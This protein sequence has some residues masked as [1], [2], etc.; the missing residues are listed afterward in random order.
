MHGAM[1]KIVCS[2]VL[3]AF[4]FSFQVSKIVNKE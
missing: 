2:S 3:T 1:V 4:F